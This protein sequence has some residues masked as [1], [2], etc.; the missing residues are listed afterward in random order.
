MGQGI[1]VEDD[2]GPASLG[3]L[4]E[5]LVHAAWIAAQIDGLVPARHRRIGR[6]PLHGRVAAIGELRVVAGAAVRAGDAQ[7]GGLN[8]PWAKGPRPSRRPR[9]RAR[10]GRGRRPR[11]SG[12]ARRWGGWLAMV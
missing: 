5:L 4:P 1:A 6:W 9:R 3:V 7:H 2:P 8:D 12:A 11:S 10:S